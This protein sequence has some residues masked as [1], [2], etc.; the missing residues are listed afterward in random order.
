MKEKI[1][2]KE[3]SQNNSKDVKIKIK[4]I[5]QKQKKNPEEQLNGKKTRL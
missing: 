1:K 4:E 3:S 2:S 5:L